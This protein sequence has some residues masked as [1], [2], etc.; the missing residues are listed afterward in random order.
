M[1]SDRHAPSD[2]RGMTLVEITIA[3][4][5]LGILFAA[6]AMT[7]TLT[8]NQ[9]KAS[10]NGVADSNDEQ[11]TL[12]Y[13]LRD[14]ASAADISTAPTDQPGG[15]ALPGSNVLHV[16]WSQTDGATTTASD[17]YYRYVNVGTE[18]QLVR[19]EYRGGAAV[20]SVPIA[21]ELAAPG[22]GWT[23]GSAV[24]ASVLSVVPRAADSL[25][26]TGVDVTMTS[27]NGAVSHYG[28]SGLGSGDPV[29]L[30]TNA[31][32][33]INP[34]TVRSR[35]FNRI[36]LLVDTSGSIPMA[37]GGSQVKAA[38]GGMVN[39]MAGMPIDMSIIG[40]DKSYYQL[41]PGFMGPIGSY[42]SLTDAAAR[43]AAIDQINLLDDQDAYYD[44]TDPNGD[45]IH[46]QQ[47]AEPDVDP[48]TGVTHYYQGGTNWDA[49]LWA[50]T[51]DAAGN[52][53]PA[54]QLPNLVV[55]I[56]DG[57]PNAILGP[58]YTD[59]A[60][61]TSAAMARADEVR[62]D[63]ID[64]VGVGVGMVFSSSTAVTNLKSVVGTTG[65]NG[66][67]PGNAATADVFVGGFGQLGSMLSTIVTGRCGGAVVMQATVDGAPA[68][69]IWSYWS[70]EAMAPGWWQIEPG[71][72]P[73]VQ[74]GYEVVGQAKRWVS[75]S[76]FAASGYAVSGF[77]C[78]SGGIPLPAADMNVNANTLQVN[79]GMNQAI[80]C[81]VQGTHP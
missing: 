69:G 61:A 79:V 14:I 63:G 75:V 43:S 13:L 55:L 15:A 81:D 74:Y 11:F 47:M 59:E 46:W 34:T 80:V 20:S 23:A 16:T 76:V 71:D 62:A 30:R 1:A 31:P 54:S 72:D 19:Y 58:T 25:G 64:L 26:R 21:H 28:G 7:L 40:F 17:V 44:I 38:V 67:S 39:A 10:R 4:V 60:E 78:T 9:S 50:V 2:E 41:S 29:P 68:P 12:S 70:P 22:V 73:V 56:T 5:V 33:W 37:A 6:L 57:Q 53:L 66:G 24:P 35:C 42:F 77:S 8:V 48:V 45:G 3:L 18:W 32:K 36:A 52:K 65:W 51:R 27:Q 49:A